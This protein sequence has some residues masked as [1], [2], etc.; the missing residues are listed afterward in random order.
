M[1]KIEL[2]FENDILQIDFSQLNADQI[3]LIKLAVGYVEEIV[4]EEGEVVSNPVPWQ[5]F[6][7]SEGVKRTQEKVRS[8]AESEIMGQ[9][10]EDAQA[11]ISPLSEIY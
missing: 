9:A 1:G 2:T 6:S 8:L 4:N 10:I 3:R 5:L 7:I 11:T